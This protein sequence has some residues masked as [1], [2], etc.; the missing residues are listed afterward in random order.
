MTQA[1]L[2]NFDPHRISSPSILWRQVWGLAALLVAILL[3]LLAY[4]FY[5][6]VI[7]TRL[8]LAQWAGTLGL[9]QGLLAAAIEPIFG[10]VSDRI[11]R[12]FGNRLP[13]ITVG[14]TVAGL[15]FVAIALF[16]QFPL[17]RGW[18]WLIPTLM[19]VW[20][21]AAIAFRG[22]AVALLRQ[23]APTEELPAANA[24]FIVLF[25]LISAVAP[26]L[27][28]LL[29]R[30]QVSVAFVC[31]AIV[32][33][34]GAFCFYR[35]A[36]LSAPIPPRS[37]GRLQDLA[38]IG[39]I[40]FGVGLL[41]GLELN[42]L[43]GIFPPV[44]GDRLFDI[45]PAW[46]ASGMMLVCSLSANPS[47]QLVVRWGAGRTM[48]V[49]LGTI[50]LGLALFPLARI[51]LLSFALTIALGMALGL[52]FIGTIPYALSAMPPDRAG[53]STGLFFGGSGAAMT[54]GTWLVQSVKLSPTT[55]FVAIAASFAIAAI[56]LNATS[57]AV[58]DSEN[59]YDSW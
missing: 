32:L 19:T 18:R 23:F 20:L 54:L 25:G 39:A 46:I 14:V 11:L 56:C 1:N 13:Q 34:L 55:G 28:L 15:L 48:Q 33:T 27:A 42:L 52:V 8:G 29:E 50:V 47:N 36:P 24:L 2:P 49:G 22:P 44:L 43:L 4:G 10:G 59:N 57:N 6:P 9:A 53:L 31:G 51:P 45:H 35:T 21:M 26:L 40:V 38:K 37:S 17:S 58:C 5:Q 12:R 30:V 16:W 3:S 7:L 41:S